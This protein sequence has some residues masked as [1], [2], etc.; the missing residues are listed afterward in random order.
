MSRTGDRFRGWQVRCGWMLLVSVLVSSCGSYASP[1]LPAIGPPSE[2]EESR[3]SREFRR[4]ARKQLK[5]VTHPEV[6]RS[7]ERIECVCG[8]GRIDLFFHRAH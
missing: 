8:T 5:F 3:I 7:I 1:V 6:E 4:E 2:D